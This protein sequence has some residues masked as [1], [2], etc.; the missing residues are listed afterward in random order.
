MRIGHLTPHCGGGVGQVIGAWLRAACARGE[1][2]WVMALEATHHPPDEVRAADPS[3][4]AVARDDR[5]IDEFM[6]LCDVLVLHWWNHPLLYRW[7]TQRAIPPARVVL[8]AHVLGAQGPYRFHDELAAMAD[9]FVLTTEASLA[10]LTPVLQALPHCCIRSTRG[11]ER[12][13]ALNLSE[14]PQRVV[15]TVTTAPD[16]SKLHPDFILASLQILDLIPDASLVLILP[17]LHSD[18]PLMHALRTLSVQDRFELYGWLEDPVPLMRTFRV[19]G[20]PLQP[21]HFGTGEQILAE[22]MLLGIAP[23]VLDN[24]PERYIVKHRETGLV[25]RSIEEYP[26]CVAELLCDPS[27]A[28]TL[29]QQAREDILARYDMKHFL[30]Q[31]SEVFA[32]V[33]SLPRRARSW[34]HRVEPTGAAIFLASVPEVRPL[35]ETGNLDALR[36]L[37]AQNP[38]WRSQSKGSPAHYARYFHDPQLW[39]WARFLAT[40]L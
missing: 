34:P 1:D 8:W 18:T 40:A 39:R 3:R 38:Q 2:H 23:V 10:Y 11:T 30:R 21:H 6:A 12:F 26:E 31:W 20:Y 29:G 25:A 13:L 28:K 5:S 27:L 7:M 4:F 32:S 16:F 9:Y 36:D 17:S 19:F 33:M 22:A 14:S 15:G 37:A 35:F 24:P